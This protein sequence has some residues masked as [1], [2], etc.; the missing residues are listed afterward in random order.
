MIGG[1]KILFTEILPDSKVQ[2]SGFFSFF[3]FTYMFRSA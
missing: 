2:Q 1:Q 3:L